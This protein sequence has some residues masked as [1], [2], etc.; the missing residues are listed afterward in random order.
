MRRCQY[1]RDARC[2]IN[3]AR[4]L[5]EVLGGSMHELQSNEL[6]AALI[7][8]ADDVAAESALDTVGLKMTKRENAKSMVSGTLENCIDERDIP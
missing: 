4:T 1:K 7:E 5:L 3:D 8:P 6:E 2:V